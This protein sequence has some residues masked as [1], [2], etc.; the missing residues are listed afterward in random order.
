MSPSVG[1]GVGAERRGTLFLKI[2][3]KNGNKIIEGNEQCKQRMAQYFTYHKV[4]Y[5]GLRRQK[6]C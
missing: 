4:G 2:T 5:T 3:K 6:K 1:W